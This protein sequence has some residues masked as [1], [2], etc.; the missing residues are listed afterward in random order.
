MLEKLFYGFF[1]FSSKFKAVKTPALSS[2][3]IITVFIGYNL[4][5]LFILVSYLADHESVPINSDNTILSLL[6]GIILMTINYFTLYSKK[7]SIIEKYN[8]CSMTTKNKY[9][10]FSLIYGLSSIIIFFTTA[11][12]ILPDIQ[13]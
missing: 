5:T 6:F 13:R 12:Y 9:I 3:L 2:Y 10:V 1:I 7:K 8:T 11:S 4:A